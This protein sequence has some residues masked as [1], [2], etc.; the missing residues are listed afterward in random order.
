[1]ASRLVA[2]GHRRRIWADREA[3]Q[4]A[5]HPRPDL[6]RGRAAVPGDRQHLPA[7]VNLRRDD[8]ASFLVEAGQ[9]YDNLHGVAL[10]GR[11]TIIEDPDELWRVGVSVFERYNAPYTEELRPFVE[12]M[13][14]ERV[15]VRVDVERSRTWD[16]R[17]LGLP[18]IALGGST[19]QF[20][21]H[22]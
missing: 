18:A 13:V 4:R 17:K 3:G 22:D 2:G 11:G 12:A 16:H 10:E 20:I 6:R 5:A 15:A 8:R 21:G 9:T 1:M 14:N 7:I 19:P